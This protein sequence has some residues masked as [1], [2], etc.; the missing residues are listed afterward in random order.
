MTVP[1]MAAHKVTT[2]GPRG[3]LLMGSLREFKSDAIGFL[4]RAVRE[5]GDLVRLRFGPV[6]AYLVNRP[7]YVQHVL[8]RQ[9]R[10]YDKNTRS[11]A[12]VRA[13]C[14]D[15]LLSSDGENWLRHRRLI[16][17]V[18][19]PQHVADFAPTV[20]ASIEEMLRDWDLHC[21][22]GRQ[23]DIVRE[24]MGLTMN[25][26]ARVLF[27]SDVGDQT[28]VIERALTVV[29]E[30]TW[31][32]LESPLDLAAVSP[33]FHRS[34]FRQSLRKID[35]IVYQIIDQRRRLGSA[36]DDLLSRLLQAR[37]SDD[38][39]P[40]L[41]DQE[42]RDAVVTLL[43]AGHETTA[44]ALASTFYLLSQ[45]SRAQDRLVREAANRRRSDQQPPARPQA[46]NSFLEA[47]R[48]YPSIWIIERRAVTDDEID[49][50]RIP[51]GSTILLSPYLLH[52]HAEF[53]HD[54][55]AFDPERFAPH[56]ISERPRYAYL[57]FGAG[58]HRCIGEHMAL[59]VATR[60]LSR[61]HR[62]YRV[63]LAA[64]QV[65]RLVPGITLR[66]EGPLRMSLQRVN[67]DFG[68]EASNEEPQ[69]R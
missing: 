3:N 47:V 30:D 69:R 38:G 7:E 24:M 67:Q 16:Q 57:P 65:I 26:A 48:I 49:G 32:R 22:R 18:F 4:Q 54:P 11:V 13:T 42:L 20:D 63:Q 55:E 39:G 61:V 45:S 21:D 36:A 44:N 6:V 29:L 12:K 28:M 62:D 60:V 50:H 52:R 17:P 46:R 51:K 66:H 5:Y 37:D 41:S 19:Q 64:D 35:E 2:P 31:R 25:I 1:G 8:V 27:E 43:L 10:R 53:W 9:S 23:I 56:R 14:G 58:P 59:L 15:S 34:S 40:R 33:W 68:T